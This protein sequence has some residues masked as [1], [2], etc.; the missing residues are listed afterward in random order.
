MRPLQPKNSSKVLCIVTKWYFSV[1]LTSGHTRAER[2]APL[3]RTLHPRGPWRLL[4]CAWGLL[5]RR[6]PLPWPFDLASCWDASSCYWHSTC[7]SDASSLILPLTPSVSRATMILPRWH[8]SLQC[9]WKCTNPEIPV[10]LLGQ[11]P[12]LE[13][14]HVPA[15]SWK[16]EHSLHLH[17]CCALMPARMPW[18]LAC[19]TGL[20]GKQHLSVTLRSL[21]LLPLPRA[22]VWVLGGLGERY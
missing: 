4:L 21:S 14:C 19:D 11:R 10:W 16:G 18:L 22:A 1:S 12:L 17:W 2:P 7:H 20:S 13:L 9:L 3:I 6:W 8:Q 15:T 5:G